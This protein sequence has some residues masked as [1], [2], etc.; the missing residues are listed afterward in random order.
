MM[1]SEL[2][3]IPKAILATL[4]YFIGIQ[5]IGVRFIIGEKIGFENSYTYYHL[6]QGI[7]Q[8][9]GVLIFIY[10]IRNRTFKNLIKKTHLKWYLC[11]LI[12]GMS[13]VFMQ[14]PLNWIYN[15][16][17]GTEY[18]IAYSIDGLAKAKFTNINIIATVLMIPIGEELFFR[19]YIQNNL[20]KKTNTVVA[21]LLTSLLF[22]SIHAPYANLILDLIKQDWHLFYLALFGGIISGIL[23]FKSKS[24]GPS[25]IFSMFWNIMISISL[26]A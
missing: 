5:L 16:I 7:L 1:K 4:L 21:I 11:A 15:L 10:F 6:I 19:G 2:I 23:Y 24:I 22:A 25:I 9:T 12:L 17:F 18:Q 26:I 3:T 20:Q 14:T 13:F 8:L